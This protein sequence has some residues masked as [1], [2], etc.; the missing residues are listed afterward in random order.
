[1]SARRMATVLAVLLAWCALP[2]PASAQLTTGTVTGAVKD[3]QG[4]VLP[5]ATVVLVS[6]S[7]GTQLPPQRSSPRLARFGS[8]LRGVRIWNAV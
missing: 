5:G 2:A 4:G 7:R 8:G 1:M 6:E 3:A